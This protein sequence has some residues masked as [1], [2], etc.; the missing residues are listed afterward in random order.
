[1]IEQGQVQCAW[2]GGAAVFW[3]GAWSSSSAS[4]ADRPPKSRLATGGG[5]KEGTGWIPVKMVHP[6]HNTY[7]GLKV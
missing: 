1:M 2:R 4:G 3:Q 5:L 6:K 7:E